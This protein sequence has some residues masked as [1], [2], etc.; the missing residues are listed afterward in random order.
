MANTYAPFGFRS[1]GHQDGSP[2]TMG[3]ERRFMLSSDTTAVFTGDVV[4]NST[5]VYGTIT[6]A[7]SGTGLAGGGYAGVFAGCEY[8]NTTVQRQVWSPYFPGSVGTTSASVIAYVISDVDMQFLA[9]GST[10]AVLGTSV[11]GWNIGFTSTGASLGNTTTGISNVG[12][13]STSVSANSSLPFRIVDVYSDFAPPG[14]NGT[15][16]TTAG[17][18]LVVLPNNWARNT[19]TGVS[20]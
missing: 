4:Q 8:Y 17:A 19:L 14:V 12:L 7:S 10:A 6:Q 13:L 2:P 11:I 20:T 16:N 18:V 3:L 9:Q 15:D 5:A 1:F